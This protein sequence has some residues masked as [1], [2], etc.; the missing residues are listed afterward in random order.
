MSRTRVLT[1]VLPLSLAL[2]DSSFAAAP[3][4]LEEPG[5]AA[6]IAA[7]RDAVDAACHCFD[8]EKS[9][10][11][12]SCANE[13]VATRIAALELRAQCRGTVRKIYAK[14]V[15]GHGVTGSGPRM[16]FVK[17][18]GS[19]K[20]RCAVKPYLSQNG[21]DCP[22]H[23]TCLDAADTNGDLRIG[24]G[25][26]DECAPTPNDF[27]DNGDGTITDNRTGLMWEKLDNDG[28][29]H[30]RD[31][32]Y[33]FA[34]AVDLKIAALN[35]GGGFAGHVDWRVPTIQELLSLVRL[36]TI[37]HH[38]PEFDTTCF[39]GFCAVPTCS[40]RLDSAWSSSSDTRDDL[41]AW[42]LFFVGGYPNTLSKTATTG[43]RAVRSV[44]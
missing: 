13:V 8:F 31:N 44:P 15:C 18:T 17:P 32:A 20:I 34:D 16:P 10:E 5:D 23:L 11:Y 27:V 36:E 22:G 26:S 21:R 6:Q 14:S 1:L 24:T 3:K 2:A 28:G 42:H 38:P 41:E 19:G 39:I 33:S 37:S 9:G 25:D 12:K 43:V 30:D 7:T 35:A 40:C 4:C 29:I